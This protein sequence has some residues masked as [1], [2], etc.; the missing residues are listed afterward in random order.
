MGDV[1]RTRYDPLTYMKT[2]GPEI[3]GYLAGVDETDRI[4]ALK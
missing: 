4:V 3:F 1:G 2:S